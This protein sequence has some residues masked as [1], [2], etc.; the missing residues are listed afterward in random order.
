M[1]SEISPTGAPFPIYHPPST[2]SAGKAAEPVPAPVVQPPLA[3]TTQEVITP[4]STE[5][6]QLERLMNQL[7]AT[8]QGSA[9]SEALSDRT[10]V[11]VLEQLVA[12]SESILQLVNSL[13]DVSGEIATM[14]EERS[15][16]R[17]Q[18]ADSL[19][20]ITGDA[21]DAI[22][23][24][25]STAEL[26][27]QGI[28]NIDLLIRLGSLFIV[29]KAVLNINSELETVNAE[30]EKAK[31]DL[32]T[33][34]EEG[35]VSGHPEMTKQTLEDSIK[36]L[37]KRI[38]E[39]QDARKTLCKDTSISLIRASIRTAKDDVGMAATLSTTTAATQRLMLVGGILGMVTGVASLG[40][41][42]AGMVENYNALKTADAEKTALK[43][44]LASPTLDPAVKEII[45]LRLKFLEEK[46]D[47]DTIGSMQNFIAIVSSSLGVSAGTAKV[48]ILA[49]VTVA[50]G[51]AGAATVVGI[52][53]GVITAGLLVCG[54]GYAAYKNRDIIRG[55]LDQVALTTQEKWTKISFE[56]EKSA[57]MAELSEKFSAIENAE[58]DLREYGQKV[59][60]K[61]GEKDRAIKAEKEIIKRTYG[62][63]ID[64]LYVKLETMRVNQEVKPDLF[65]RI[66]QVFGRKISEEDKELSVK[67]REVEI[68]DRIKQLNAMAISKMSDLD[69]DLEAYRI[70]K[71]HKTLHKTQVLEDLT[72]SAQRL[73]AKVNELERGQQ[74]RLDLIRIQKEESGEALAAAKLS[75]KFDKMLPGDVKENVTK[76][77]TLLRNPESKTEAEKFMRKFG[78]V[79]TGFEEDPVA[80][81]FKF[82]TRK[83]EKVEEETKGP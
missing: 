49:G 6:Q 51:T 33:F 47:Q 64:R 34:E 63:N 60:R 4:T 58:R 14:Q 74:A 32:K 71:S 29:G 68:K 70:R 7:D 56:R 17:I 16:A 65:G 50:A 23:K 15:L 13:P 1:F 55:N 62:A 66:Q 5:Q 20:K 9:A 82:L 36:V 72:I 83:P 12:S 25:G 22:S 42:L 38:S 39:L 21:T 52:G 40:L 30:L 61:W 19:V 79:D 67:M 2:E 48:L 76:M 54:A 44:E 77:Q 57:A 37:N 46:L 53:A 24:L 26:A 28:S 27:A 31:S 35:S 45:L 75:V 10:E 80:G 59:N 8:I 3:E 78:F 81:V 43:A 11:A 69:K 18:S 73:S 41:N